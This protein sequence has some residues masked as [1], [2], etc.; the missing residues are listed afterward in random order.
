MI[1][2]ELTFRDTSR[3]FFI[4]TASVVQWQNVTFLKVEAWD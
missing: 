3:S 1:K 4:F 2:Y